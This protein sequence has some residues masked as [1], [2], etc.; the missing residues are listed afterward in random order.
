MAMANQQGQ[1]LLSTGNISEL[2]LGYCTLYVDMNGGLA[3]IGDLY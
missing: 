1:L 3:V 2:A